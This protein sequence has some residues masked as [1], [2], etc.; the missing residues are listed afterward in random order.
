MQYQSTKKT[1]CLAAFVA[2]GQGLWHPRQ[3]PS[4]NETHQERA[5]GCAGRLTN[6]FISRQVVCFNPGLYSLGDYQVI[7]VHVRQAGG[8]TGIGTMAKELRPLS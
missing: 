2:R 7:R 5:D 8:G 6:A 3:G 4:R 1:P